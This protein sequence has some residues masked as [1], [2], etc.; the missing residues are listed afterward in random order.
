MFI[1][2]CVVLS[3]A[4][5]GL[6]FGQSS[7]QQPYE[8]HDVEL[9]WQQ[10]AMKFSEAIMCV[11]VDLGVNISETLL[12]SSGVYVMSFVFACY[13]STFVRHMGDKG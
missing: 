3:C 12:P 9:S 7:I 8:I 1:F 5:R 13:V 11:N 10:Y 2:L 4:D 6:A